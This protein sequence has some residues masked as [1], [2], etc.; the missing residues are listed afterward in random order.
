MVVA[1]PGEGRPTHSLRNLRQGLR[2]AV[3]DH[4]RA[5]SARFDRYLEAVALEHGY[6]VDRASGYLEAGF[7]RL[8]E[9]LLAT[10]R[11]DEKSF[12]ASCDALERAARNARTMQELLAA[13]RRA[14]ADLLNA[15]ERPLEARHDRG[16]RAA[17]DHIDR[18]YTEPLDV[19]KVA[20]V[21]GFTP[22]YF[23]KLFSAREKMTF[24]DYVA[25]RRVERAK[26]AIVRHWP[27]CDARRRAVG[28][29]LGTIF[30]AGVP[31]SHRYDTARLSEPPTE[32]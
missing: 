20:R 16:L 22:N 7:D 9:T 3:G 26:E 4:S 6:R 17:L 25:L 30:F 2:G 31:P 29:Q 32:G 14:A 12:Q 21:A 18:H 13:Y 27:R 15:V 10:G 5:L 24:V 1:E 11:L 23:S 8:A 19:T 28:I